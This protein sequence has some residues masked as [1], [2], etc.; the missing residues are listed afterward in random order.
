MAPHDAG[1]D[2]MNRP[3]LPAEE[4]AK[5]IERR[6]P[7]RVP[8]M[9]AQYWNP[10]DAFGD[11]A[12]EVLDIQREYPQDAYFVRVR[13]PLI[14]EDPREPTHVPGYTWM[15]APPPPGEPVRAQKDS[16]LAI[17]D[18]SQLDFMLEHWPEPTIPRLFEP[19]PSE[20]HGLGGGR[21]L[22]IYWAYC[23]YERLWTLRGME[24]TLCDFC[25]NP[26][27][28]H[29]LLEAITEFHCAVIRRGARD[30][31]ARAV[32]TTD[33]LGMQ[34]G[35]MFSR[36]V[37]RTFFRDRYARLIRTAHENGMHFWLHSC[38]NI[39][40]FLDD[41]VDR[42]LDVLHPVQKYAMDEAAIARR[43]GDRLCFWTGMDVQRILP[44]GTPNDVRREVRFM[45]DTYDR[46]DGGCMIT[47]GNGITS[48][49]P[50]AN[51]RAFY[52]ESYTYG[53]EHRRNR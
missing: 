46:A 14:W 50:L 25:E 37:F 23:L 38:G 4:V 3:A 17:T 43:Y 32:W 51:L 9:I 16:S 28:V 2:F 15:H 29:R 10:A 31:G 22:G 34:T 35:P 30:L 21:Y 19:G 33:D 42:E 24:N 39:E 41:F 47:A 44:F 6:N 1:A 49:V 36:E 26:E 11:R 12:A 40:P 5:A 27:P 53:I 45:I 20:A 18:W 48:D 8:M 7:A 13:R 52:D